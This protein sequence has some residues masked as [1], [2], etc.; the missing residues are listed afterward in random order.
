M[1]PPA[2]KLLLCPLLSLGFSRP[3]YPV[4]YLSL[5]RQLNSHLL[6]E[7]SLI[8]PPLQAAGTTSSVI[9]SGQSSL[10]PN[11]DLTLEAYTHLHNQCLTLP[12]A[13]SSGTVGTMYVFFPFFYVSPGFN[14]G[15]GTK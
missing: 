3:L 6:G 8:P 1:S 11:P 12:Q 7:A 4:I 15:S 14:T 13:R 10:P 5:G 9:G 2:T